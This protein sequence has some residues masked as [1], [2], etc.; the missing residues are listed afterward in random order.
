MARHKIPLV[1]GNGIEILGIVAA[2]YLIVVA[3][4]INNVLVKLLAYLLSWACLEFFPHCLAHFAIGRLLGVRFTSYILSKSPAAKLRLPV[5]SAAASV[6]PILGLKIDQSSL[7]SVSRGARAVMF[8]S[9]AAVSMIFPFFVVVA[10]IG[11]LP[12][13]LSG[14]LLLL[15][16]ANLTLD[17]YYSPKAGDISRI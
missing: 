7:A 16:V 3:P 17:L 12:A 6:I 9:G 1:L 2:I 13:I 11:R 14:G 5:I 10:S 8:A 15:S 4:D